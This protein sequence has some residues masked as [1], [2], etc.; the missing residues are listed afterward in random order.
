MTFLT[1]SNI[2][3]REGKEAVL[4][5]ISFTQQQ[6]KK[7]AIAGET[8]SG[9]STLLKIIGGLIQPNDGEVLFENKH[10]EGPNE[11]LIPGHPHIAYL[12]QH[13]EL[14]NNYR[15]EEILEYANIL[16]GTQAE[17]LYDVCRISHLLKRKTDQLSG[18]ERQRI[19]LARLL[20]T[21]PRLLLLDEPFSNLDIAHKNVLKSVI[22]DIGQK[23]NITCLLVSHEPYDVLSWADEIIVLKDGEIVQTGT[24]DKIYRHPVNAYVA[25]LFGKYNLIHPINAPLFSSLNGNAGNNKSIFIRPENLK[26]NSGENGL[27]ADV[28]SVRFAGIFYELEV[29]LPDNQMIIIKTGHRNIAAG[30]TV[31]ISFNPEDTWYL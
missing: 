1:L 8:G 4:K 21:S 5:N 11:R 14:R 18:G 31:Y 16:S 12:S 30:D 28:S 26:I 27:K 3:K 13:F 29:V 22:A 23:L 15:V 10:V 9:K 2:T 17:D 25:G 7:T 20:T 19:A 6:S 24:P